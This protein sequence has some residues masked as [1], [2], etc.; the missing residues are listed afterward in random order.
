MSVSSS[1]A[2]FLGGA[3]LSALTSSLYASGGWGG[4]CI[5]GAVTAAL[6]LV[7]WLVTNP[8]LSPQAPQTDR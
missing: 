6:A 7:A 4:V 3:V 5:L 1:V 2:Y 8:T